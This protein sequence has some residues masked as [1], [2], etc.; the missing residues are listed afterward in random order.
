[1]TGKTQFAVIGAPVPARLD[2]DRTGMRAWGLLLSQ[3][4]TSVSVQ[5]LVGAMEPVEQ[6]APTQESRKNSFFAR[7]QLSAN[8]SAPVP[9]ARAGT[10]GVQLPRPTQ[11]AP[12]LPRAGALCACKVGV[13]H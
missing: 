1:M 10:W 3:S 9:I 6:R 11:G 4:G 2:P 5:L 8:R 13:R 7:P 12:V